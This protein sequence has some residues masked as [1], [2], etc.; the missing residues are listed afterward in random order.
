MRGVVG[1]LGGAL[2]SIV[3]YFEEFLFGKF[4]SRMSYL[5][6]GVKDQLVNVL[7]VFVLQGGIILAYDTRQEFNGAHAHLILFVETHFD[8]ARLKTTREQL[9]TRVQL[10]SLVQRLQRGQ[11]FD[12]TLALL[13]V[14]RPANV[15]LFSLIMVLIN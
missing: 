6:V 14:Q 7:T 5:P 11:T 8:N 1:G 4:A 13:V 2:S 10:V 9:E 15:L 3:L 12:A